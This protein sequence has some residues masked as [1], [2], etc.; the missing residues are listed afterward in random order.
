MSEQIKRLI[1]Q[2]ANV[3]E[4]MK[5]TLD[6]ADAE[7]RDLSV[8]ENTDFEQRTADL[9]R[10]D[11]RI[12]S[13]TDAE[14]R[15][16]DIQASF[17]KIQKRGQRGDIR[18]DRGGDATPTDA[19]R[20]RAVLTG[21][22]RSDV[23][24]P[25]AGTTMSRVIESRALSKLTSAAGG[26][27]IGQTFYDRLI[28]HLIETAS[29]V[30][31]ASTMTTT[32]GEQIA[33]PKTTAHGTAALVAEAGTIPQGD[34]TF[35]QA[36]L[37]A[38]KYGDL[39]QISHELVNDTGFDLEGYVARQAGRAVGN[40]FG[41]HLMTGTGTNQPQGLIPAVT[42]GKTGATTV[43]GA[44]T[45]DD[46]IDLKYSVIAPYRNGP[47]VGW[48]LRDASVGALRKLKTAQGVYLWEPGL[49]VGEPS[50]F[51]GDPIYTEI[52]VPAIAT[53]AK[54]VL[55]GDFS[56]YMVRLVEGLRFESSVDFAFNTDLITY[57]CLL[58]G[59]GEL[60]DTTGAIKAFQGA[61]S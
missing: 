5:A 50:R 7:K 17:E 32:T 54:S 23:F 49:Q 42:V 24:T 16:A 52:N 9:S 10:L 40:A 3:W 34:P 33:V 15:D 26:N 55:Y 57:R 19:A 27:L 60:L 46:L 6:R 39:I 37:D 38:Y 45:V 53:S 1:D 56:A 29:L 36:F 2:R 59:D 48:M 35:G 31:V 44:F 14:N 21:E 47:R 41:A 18:E 58:R 8:E 12:A 25:A 20:L 4:G 61:A 43:G 30:N 51:D 13:L 11:E 28:E 22:K